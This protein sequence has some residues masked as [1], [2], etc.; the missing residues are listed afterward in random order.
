VLAGITRV[1][2]TE[3]AADTFDVQEAPLHYDELVGCDEIFITSSTKEALPVTQI[4]RHRIGDGNPGL[5][6]RKLMELFRV[7]VA[8]RG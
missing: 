1:V 2:V 7:Y 5:H 4:D 3:I 8:H 6:I